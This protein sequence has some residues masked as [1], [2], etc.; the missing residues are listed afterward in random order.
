MNGLIF[1]NFKGDTEDEIKALRKKVENLQMAR[2][3]SRFIINFN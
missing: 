3:V 2:Q 1:A